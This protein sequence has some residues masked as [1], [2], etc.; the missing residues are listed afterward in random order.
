LFNDVLVYACLLRIYCST[1]RTKW[2]P[3]YWSVHHYDLRTE[4]HGNGSRRS[5][6]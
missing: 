3:N 5:D 6:M 2:T 1:A 4:S